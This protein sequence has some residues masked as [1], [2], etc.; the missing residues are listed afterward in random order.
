MNKERIVIKIG[1]DSVTTNNNLN[2]GKIISIASDISLL[3][4]LGYEIILISSGAIASGIKKMALEKKPSELSEKRALSAIGQC[5]FMEAWIKSFHPQ[6]VAQ[7]LLTWKELADEE[8]KLKAK[9]TLFQLL[10]WQVIPVINENDA[11]ADEEIRFGDNDLL[12]LKVAKLV[13]AKRLIILTDV[14]G[15]FTADPKKHKD[16]KLIKVV[17]KVDD[18]IRKMISDTKSQY[19]S[20]GMLSKLIVA[21]EA[22]KIGITVNILSSKKE[23]LLLYLVK[24]GLNKGTEFKKID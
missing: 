22:M 5:Y 18:S 12:A 16:A 24:Y 19:G 9:E 20:G 2:Y 17:T 10:K 14:E 4:L 8:S 3:H 15:L 1:S 13:N 7:V 11:I 6:L 23:G 21:E